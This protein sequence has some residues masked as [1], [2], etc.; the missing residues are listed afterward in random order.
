MNIAAFIN[1]LDFPPGST[2][3]QFRAMA[4][5]LVPLGYQPIFGDW[6]SP[7]N[8]ELSLDQNLI[9]IGHSLGGHEAIK[10]CYRLFPRKVLGLVLL[11]A[12][13]QDSGFFGQYA[14]DDFKVPPNVISPLSIKRSAWFPP[15]SRGFDETGFNRTVNIGHGEFPKHPGIIMQVEERVA[16]LAA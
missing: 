12:V 6:N 4:D 3:G 7:P 5:A 16:R 2:R 14:T 10:L 15:I 9:I 8:P 11:D 1:G 13:H